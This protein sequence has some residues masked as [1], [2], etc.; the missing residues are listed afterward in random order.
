[1]YGESNR[2]DVSSVL[3]ISLDFLKFIAGLFFA[4]LSIAYANGFN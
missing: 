3:K 1:M 2:A 4:G